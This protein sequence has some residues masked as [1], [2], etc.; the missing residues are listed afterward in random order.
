MLPA[1]P[2]F[3][4]P[5]SQFTVRSSQFIASGFKFLVFSSLIGNDCVN[6]TCYRFIVSGSSFGA[7]KACWLNLIVVS[8]SSPIYP[9]SR[10]A[11]AKGRR[12]K[13]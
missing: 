8:T 7:I 9:P 10:A 1:K 3:I 13:L 4:V 6:A 5:G 11:T 12:Q 2:Q